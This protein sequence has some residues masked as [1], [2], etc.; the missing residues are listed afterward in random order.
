[1][2]TFVLNIYFFQIDQLK[3]R[4]PVDKEY[5]SYLYAVEVN[6]VKY[7]SQR[8]EFP[9]EKRQKDVLYLIARE[10]SGTKYPSGFSFAQFDVCVPETFL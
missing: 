10:D 4:P 8:T 5:K 2:I 6:K 9:Q 3:K 7:Q 1:M